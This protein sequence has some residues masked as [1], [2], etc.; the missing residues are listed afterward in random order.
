MGGNGLSAGT[1]RRCPTCGRP[2]EQLCYDSAEGVHFIKPCGDV[3]KVTHL[4]TG[5]LLVET[6]DDARP[7]DSREKPKKL[8]TPDEGG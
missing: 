7:F 1:M 8:W 5:G 3:V 4:P 6:V 2:A